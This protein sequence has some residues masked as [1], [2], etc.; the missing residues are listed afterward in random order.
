MTT[1]N[2]TTMTTTELTA[3]RLALA[4]EEEFRSEART[5]RNSFNSVVAKLSNLAEQRGCIPFEPV[6]DG[7]HLPG[8]VVERYGSCYRNAS[9]SYLSDPPITHPGWEV[10]E[11]PAEPEEEPVEENPDVEE[12][13]EDPPGDEPGAPEE[14]INQEEPEPEE[15]EPDSEQED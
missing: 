12:P 13:T 15:P 10:Y 7:G 1:P 4:K 6:P 5:L 3:M 11:Q 9:G 8:Q 2:F 14:P